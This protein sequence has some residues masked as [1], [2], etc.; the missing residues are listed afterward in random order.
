MAVEEAA[1]RL[2]RHAGIE[3][4]TISGGEP[5][6]QALPLALLLEW[7]RSTTQLSVLAF[8]G[9]TVE[10]L[11]GMPG[12]ARA[13]ACMDVIVAGRYVSTQPAGR[14]L[15]GSQSQRV[16]LLTDRYQASDLAMVPEAELWIEPDGGLTTSG[17]AAVEPL[18][19]GLAP[20]LREGRLR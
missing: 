7:V 15:I 12:S 4:V 3:G 14:G 19:C 10:E 1:K 18:T 11:R 13:L 2:T 5:F 6:Q 9:Y 16:H 20:V 17:L 8:T